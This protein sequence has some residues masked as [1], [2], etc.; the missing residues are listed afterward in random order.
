MLMKSMRL[1]PSLTQS[2]HSFIPSLPPTIFIKYLSGAMLSPGDMWPNEI[3]A[4]F[5]EGTTSEHVRHYVQ[6]IIKMNIRLTN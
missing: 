4:D 1:F 2:L 5:R 6:K 3:D